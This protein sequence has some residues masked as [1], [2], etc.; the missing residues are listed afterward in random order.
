MIETLVVAI[1]IPSVVG[2]NRFDL[3][4]V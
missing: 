2:R 3:K 4:V 1:S